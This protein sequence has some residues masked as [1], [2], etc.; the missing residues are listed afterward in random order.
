MRPINEII[1]HCTATRP[2]WRAGRPT[3][4][5]VAEVRRWHMQDRGWKDIGYHFLI[6]RDGTIAEGRPLDQVG[7]H[8][9]DHN[10][11]T[12]GISLFGGHGSA[13]T[14]HFFDHYTAQQDKAL[15][16]LIEDISAKYKITKVSGHNEY[17]AKACPGFNV[18]T[19]F[20]QKRS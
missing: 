1:V 12:V 5:K 11:G 4:E 10:T 6:D 7:A 19:W 16:A 13:A 17:A 8:T 18:P 14:D 15:R 2:E 3:W 9:L 20:G